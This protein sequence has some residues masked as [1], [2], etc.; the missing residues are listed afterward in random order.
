VVC[1]PQTQSTV[2]VAAPRAGF[3]GQPIK[4]IIQDALSGYEELPGLV[5]KARG[6]LL[7][8]DQVVANLTGGTTLMGIAVQRLVEAAER[9]DRPSRRFA[10]IDRRPSAEQ[11]QN[12]YVASDVYWLDAEPDGGPDG[13]D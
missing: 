3:A 8:A 10:L 6:W 4:L 2:E 1:S 7:E 13:D 11:E 5:E 9:L 12:P